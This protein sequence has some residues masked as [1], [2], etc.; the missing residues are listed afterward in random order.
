M[1]ASPLKNKEDNNMKYNEIAQRF[2]EIKKKYEEEFKQIPKFYAFDDKQYD[3]GLE[4]LARTHYVGHVVHV[5]CGMYMNSDDVGLLN[6]HCN[7]ER[8]EFRAWAAESLE[9]LEFVIMYEMDNREL[10]EAIDDNDVLDALE[11]YRDL[12]GF[13]DAYERTREKYFKKFE[14]V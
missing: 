8:A 14:Y 13:D 6:D 12:P 3:E 1:Q 10:I 9:N 11:K 4:E 2:N 7:R 5:M